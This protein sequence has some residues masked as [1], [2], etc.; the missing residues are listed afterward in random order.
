MLIL[1]LVNQLNCIHKKLPETAMWFLFEQGPWGKAGE[2]GFGAR[3]FL[4]RSEMHYQA[5]EWKGNP[6][7]DFKNKSHSITW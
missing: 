5:H 7:P 2:G 4:G 1:I 6:K 3:I